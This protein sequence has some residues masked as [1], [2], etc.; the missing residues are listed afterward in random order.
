MTN[1][2]AHQGEVASYCPCSASTSGCLRTPRVDVIGGGFGVDTE[3][4]RN[5]GNEILPLTP[6]GL[7]ELVTAS[8]QPVNLWPDSDV[9]LDEGSYPAASRISTGSVSASLQR[10]SG[11]C[12][13]AEEFV[14]CKKTLHD[15]NI[16][17]DTKNNSGAAEVNVDSSNGAALACF[18]TASEITSCAAHE[19]GDAVDSKAGPE[20]FDAGNPALFY[21]CGSYPSS[22][23]TSDHI[24]ESI[25]GVACSNVSE[26]HCQQGLSSVLLQHASGEVGLVSL[27]ESPIA[28]VKPDFSTACERGDLDATVQVATPRILIMPESSGASR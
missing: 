11:E 25:E 16:V 8:S 9:I 13:Y 12:I 22:R 21:T 28:P 20:L 10:E 3:T 1:S 17:D 6:S 24:D 23:I 27:V 15:Q 5:N 14:R 4:K 18:P 7:S 19:N 2:L 26:S